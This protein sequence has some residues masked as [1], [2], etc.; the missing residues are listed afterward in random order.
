[1][2]E[3]KVSLGRDEETGVPKSV[4]RTFKGNRRDADD[5]LAKFYTEVRRGHAAPVGAETVAELLDAYIED[6]GPTPSPATMSTYR[7]ARSTIAGTPLARRKLSR[8]SPLDV[9]ATYRLLRER[10]VTEHTLRQIH[11]FLSSAF[12]QGVRW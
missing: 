8:V 4:T 12:R 6:R 10:E 9:D 11:R 7:R 1:V 2:G 3:L 5:A